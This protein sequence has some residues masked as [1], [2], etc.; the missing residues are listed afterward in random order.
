MEIL[1]QLGA[2]ETAFIQFFLFIVSISF[3]TLVVYKPYFRAYDSRHKLTKGAD[4]VADETQVEAKKLSQIYAARAR[5][6]ND[7]INAIFSR[8]KAD[9]LKSVGI[10]TGAAKTSAAQST[11]IARKEIVGQKQNAEQQI[12]TIAV[13][14][15]ETIVQKMTGGL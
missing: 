13:E 14:I 2:N 8:S 9:S 15:S 3:L 1:S 7:K 5:E 12:K 6:I 4:Q 11:E 10:I